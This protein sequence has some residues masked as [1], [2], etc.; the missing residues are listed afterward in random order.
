VPHLEARGLT[1]VF[2]PDP[3]SVVPLLERGVGK[4][5]I[6]ER[7]GHT[8]GLQDVDVTVE[9]GET[10]VVMGL[11]G[12]GKS[13]LVRCL[14][15]LIEPTA[16]TL[17]LDGIDVL[18]LGRSA[19]RELRRRRMGMVFQRFALLPHRS[20][21]DNVGFGLQVQG[22]AR[23]ERLRRAG[24]WVERV[25]LQGYEHALP[26]ELSGGMQQRV[27]L[28]RALAT[29][30]ELLLMDE[31]FSALDPLIRREMQDELLRLQE[32][33]TKTIVFITHDLD[34]A[35]RLGD[36]VAMLK[37]GLMVQVGTP[38]DIV[39]HPAD[40]YVRAFVE[41]VDR[42]RVL[43]VRHV[44]RPSPEV[45]PLPVP[46]APV[47]AAPV[48]AAPGAPASVAADAAKGV[49]LPAGMALHEA[50]SVVAERAGPVPV[51]DASGRTV[52]CLDA[53]TALAALVRGRGNE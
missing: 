32:E 53:A 28:A 24:A 1:K 50:L 19:L 47:P 18:S 51:V 27:G 36:R 3:A 37:D 43:K 49:V 23:S 34:E 52:G 26:R 48:P 16:G 7:T 22:V 9:P 45:A 5:E 46:A 21:L 12:S 15:R 31:A 20:V 29:D 39:M 25:G 13:T 44:M 41:H 38:A 10:F 33:L 4:D 2:G 17:T 30:P 42:S 40:D 8:V 35:L 14:N 6:L 11:S